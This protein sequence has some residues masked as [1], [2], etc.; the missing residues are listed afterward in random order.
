[1]EY[2]FC[3]KENFVNKRKVHYTV[4]L[5]IS[6]DCRCCKILPSFY[7]FL[8]DIRHLV[9]FSKNFIMAI[10]NEIIGTEPL[11]ENH[12]FWIKNERIIVHQAEPEFV[13]V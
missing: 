4:I 11:T 7:L 5:N 12:T 3:K 8:F 6:R 13:N 10:L 2:V 9:L 1:M